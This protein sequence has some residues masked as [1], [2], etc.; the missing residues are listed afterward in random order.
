MLSADEKQ[1]IESA[2]KDMTSEVQII[3]LWVSRL[4]GVPINEGLEKLRA[5]VTDWQQDLGSTE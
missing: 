4:T 2:S 3:L 5:A 1:A